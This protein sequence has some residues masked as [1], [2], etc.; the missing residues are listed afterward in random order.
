MIPFQTTCKRSDLNLTE[1]E[2]LSI[3]EREKCAARLAI[4]NHLFARIEY[5]L[6][7]TPLIV[8]QSDKHSLCE[9]TNTF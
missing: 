6:N 4:R 2:V 9:K 5:L 7:R 1:D 8:I 3:V